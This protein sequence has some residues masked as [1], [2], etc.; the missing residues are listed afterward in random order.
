M[1]S[2]GTDP[3]DEG[4]EGESEEESDGIRIGEEQ[5]ERGDKGVE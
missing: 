5:R 1:A 4:N 3:E 2:N